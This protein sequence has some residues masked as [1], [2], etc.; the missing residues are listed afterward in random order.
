M[1][2]TQHL[3]S[4]LDGIGA[5]G[6]LADG[7]AST[8]GGQGFGRGKE[9]EEE[10]EGTW[11]GCS[12]GGEDGWKWPDLAEDGR[13]RPWWPARPSSGGGVPATYEVG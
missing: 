13:G 11:M 1:K 6:G 10:D 8:P 12:P 3:L 5:D 4:L 7:V 9:I 2:N